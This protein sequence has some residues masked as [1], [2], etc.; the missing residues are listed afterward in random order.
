MDGTE[1]YRRGGVDNVS[2]VGIACQRQSTAHN[3]DDVVLFTSTA[4]PREAK[5]EE[6]MM[7]P[8]RLGAR[9][10]RRAPTEPPCR[11]FSLHSNAPS[12]ET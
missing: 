9:R 1:T 6:R 11:P 5:C 7:M 2:S 8:R 10:R 12:V 3:T 4:I